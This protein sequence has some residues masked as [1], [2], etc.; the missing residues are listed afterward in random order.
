MP[1][2]PWIVA[3]ERAEVN[4]LLGVDSPV[5]H[6]DEMRRLCPELD[7]STHPDF[8]IMAAPLPPAGGRDPPDAVVGGTRVMADRMGVHVHQGT[9]VT[10][11][12]V[13]GGRVTGVRTNRGDIAAG[14]VI[15]AV[16]GWTSEVCR[17]A[18][19]ETPIVTH[20]LRRS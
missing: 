10:G 9:E 5:I 2:A 3:H 8:P 12:D 1:S 17:M 13:L 19:V 6:P 14:I 4:R 16:A 11:I 15:S 7:L 18:G 20:P